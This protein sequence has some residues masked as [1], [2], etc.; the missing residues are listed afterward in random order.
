LKTEL[1]GDG[2]V[3]IDSQ[4]IEQAVLILVDNAA[5]YG[6]PGGTVTLASSVRSGELR[7]SVEDDGPGIPKEE[8]PR[9]FERF[10]RLDKARSRQLGGTGLGLPIAKTI[11]EA[12]GGR[13]EAVSHLG[14]GTK[15]SL[16][17]PLLFTP[18]PTE[19]KVG[20]ASVL[21][22]PQAPRH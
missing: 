6:R 14:E 21:D 22:D 17:L 10:Y 18:Q 11:V 20:R 4:K 16:C 5:K 7:I 1:G 8:L 12:H 3:K 19:G 15:I 9:I 13:L 2:F